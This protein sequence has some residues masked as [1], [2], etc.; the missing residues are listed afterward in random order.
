ME[1][2]DFGKSFCEVCLNPIPTITVQV[3]GVEVET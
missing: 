1:L 3:Q 2:T